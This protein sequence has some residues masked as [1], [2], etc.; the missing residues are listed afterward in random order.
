MPVIESL[1]LKVTA[2]DVQITLPFRWIT[3]IIFSIHWAAATLLFS[4]FG[5]DAALTIGLQILYDE[6]PLLPSPIKTNNGFSDYSY[7]TRIDSDATAVKLRH[8]VSRLSFFKFTKGVKGLFIDSEKRFSIKVQ[9][10]LSGSSNS[11]IKCMVEGW[12]PL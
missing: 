7:D 11:V 8:L 6:Q 3:R 12:R 1:D 2:Q 5:V 9:D 4:T 10:D